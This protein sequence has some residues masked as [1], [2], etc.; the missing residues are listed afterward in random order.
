MTMFVLADFQKKNR[1]KN[2]LNRLE[3]LHYINLN[4]TYIHDRKILGNITFVPF[5]SYLFTF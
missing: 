3:Q 4:N 2:L 5:I 1:I